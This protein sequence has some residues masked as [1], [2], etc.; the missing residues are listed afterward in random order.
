MDPQNNPLKPIRKYALAL[1]IITL[2]IAGLLIW[3]R[4]GDDASPAMTEHSFDGGHALWSIQ[5]YAAQVL[6]NNTF[7]LE[8]HDQAGA[9]LQ[10]ADIAVQLDMLHMVC[11]DFTFKMTEMTPGFYQGEGIPLMAGTW[12][13]T[14]TLQIGDETYTLVRHFKAEH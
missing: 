3:L 2:I 14:S 4:S 11:G 6:H 12:K 9:P 10:G 13:A 7:T 1:V 8:L 5:P